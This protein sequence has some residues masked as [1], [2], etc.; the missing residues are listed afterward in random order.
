M[1]SPS[2]TT[3]A[4]AHLQEMPAN[5][6]DQGLEG[7][8][9]VQAWL[10]EALRQAMRFR[11]PDGGLDLADPERPVL[12]RELLPEFQLPAGSV[13]AEYRQAEPPGG[14]P[15]QGSRNRIA[16]G[17]RLE[18]GH[19]IREALL[20][21]DAG[22][23]EDRTGTVVWPIRESDPAGAWAFHP[24]GLFLP[25]APE[26]REVP[27]GEAPLRK[28]RFLE[29][30]R[31][32]EEEDSFQE[33]EVYPAYFQQMVAGT[34]EGKG[35]TEADLL[36]RVYADVLADLLVLLDLCAARACANVTA[37]SDHSRGAVHELVGTAR[38]GGEQV[39]VQG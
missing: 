9:S 22:R 3:P 32:W 8:A 12:A 27:L 20:P 28:R 35:L 25:D 2:F 19:P 33:L 29:E 6:R 14:L 10:V 38:E 36:E 15:E 21:P 4:L 30:V 5:L 18:A 23:A 34:M 17:V 1:E 16:L 13:A 7:D 26:I 37:A 11:L 39:P 31:G 24:W